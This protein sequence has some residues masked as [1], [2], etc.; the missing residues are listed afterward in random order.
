M[1]GSA[2]GELEPF[3][4]ARLTGFFPFFHA[5]IAGQHAAGLEVAA[6]V[7][8]VFDEGAGDA[9]TERTG[10][11]GCAAAG[12]VGGNVKRTFHAREFQR[13]QNVAAGRIGRK[14]F[15]ESF[16]VDRDLARTRF[17]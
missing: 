11:S 13:L 3:A 5:G 6:E 8:I 16:V 1:K 17:Q 15:F 4:G 7:F 2:L 9:V 10:L 12:D 14:I